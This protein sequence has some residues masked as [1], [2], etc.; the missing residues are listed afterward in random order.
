V[1]IILLILALAGGVVLA[2]DVLIVEKA[3]PAVDVYTGETNS[4]CTWIY[5]SENP[6]DGVS[7]QNSL[8]LPADATSLTISN[9]VIADANR[10]AAQSKI[11]HD[12]F[13]VKLP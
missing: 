5:R 7:V 11:P 1:R 6:R 12:A 10:V 9:A 8:T 3:G 13:E 4:A 2:A